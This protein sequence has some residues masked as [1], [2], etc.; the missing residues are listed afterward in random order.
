VEKQIVVPQGP[1]EGIP[2]TVRAGPFLFVSGC[3][4]HR[5]LKTGRIVPSLAAAAEDQCEN[6][7]GRIRDL[8]QKAGSDMSSVVRLDHVTSSQDWLQRRQSVRGRIFGKP[9]PLASTGVAAKMQGINMLTAFVIAVVDTPDKQVLVPGPRYAMENISA[10]VRGGPLVF[11]SGIRGTVD[12]RSGMRVAEE[13][14]EAFGEQTRVCYE[15]IA[16]I[17]RECGLRPDSILRVDCFIR[18]PSRAAED[19]AIRQEVLGPVLCAA[20]RVALPL[21][22][23]GETEITVL[24]AASGIEKLV[25]L[26]GQLGLPTVTRA[27]GLLFVGE[28]RGMDLPA[29]ASANLALIGNRKAQ[30]VKAL[31]VLESSLERCGSALS[32]TVRLEIYLRDIYFADAACAILRDR[33][34]ES[35]PTVAIMGA[36]LEDNLEV[37]L[38][39][40]AV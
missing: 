7:Y 38:N 15:I 35:P 36:E 23:R 6:S 26:T 1:I 16:S 29:N 20:T 28:C 17:L 34:K 30:L 31:A 40:I 39:A 9:A 4:G 22:A 3:D 5:D 32:R 10:A 2:G 27:G 14:P 25:A 8:L 24:A 33:F 37:K 18:D 21:S 13:T 11:V 12:P 19:E